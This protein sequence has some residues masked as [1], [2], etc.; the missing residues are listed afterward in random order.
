MLT[1][2]QLTGAPA[3]QMLFNMPQRPSNPSSSIFLIGMP[4][5]GKSTIGKS[6]SK[7]LGLK[8]I[9]ADKEMV[10]RTGVPIATIFEIEGEA[11]FRAREVELIAELVTRPG[12]VLA[13]GGGAILNAESRRLLHESGA[14]VYL[15]TSLAKLCERTQRDAKRPLL[16]GVDALATLTQLLAVREPL[17][18][19]TAHFTV[20]S[21]HGSV[22]KLVESIV[23]QL[24]ERGLWAAET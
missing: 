19:E 17:Y 7:R 18:S 20:E 12:L 9:D 14:V 15:R 21:G 6:L 5:A 10:S 4:G 22:S 11:G 1:F 16:Q 23:Q 24:I 13:T 3:F 2:Y 8:F